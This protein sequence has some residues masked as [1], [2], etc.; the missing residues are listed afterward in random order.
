M[1]LYQKLWKMMESYALQ[2]VSL[3]IGEVSQFSTNT[4]EELSYG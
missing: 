1:F 2:T 3:S 4:I